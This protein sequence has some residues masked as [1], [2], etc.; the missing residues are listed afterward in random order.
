MNSNGF[1]GMLAR[2]ALTVAIMSA[3]YIMIFSPFW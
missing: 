1:G 2:L 3:V